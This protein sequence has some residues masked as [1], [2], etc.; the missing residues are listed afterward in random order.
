MPAPALEISLSSAAVLM[1][2]TRNA[3]G[4]CCCAR[5]RR[6]PRLRVAGE[7]DAKLIVLDIDAVSFID[8]SGLRMLIEAHTLPRERQSAPPHPRRPASPTPLRARRRQTTTVIHRPATPR[9]RNTAARQPARISA[10]PRALSSARTRCNPQRRYCAT[11]DRAKPQ[12]AAISLTSS[13]S[14][15]ASSMHRRSTAGSANQAP[16]INRRS[17]ANR[18]GVTLSATLR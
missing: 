11:D 4:R 15:K 7:L 2:Q 8:A 17:S 10:Q 12:R 3:T 6:V 14:K 13:P 9:L 16:G 1:S 5:L 18:S